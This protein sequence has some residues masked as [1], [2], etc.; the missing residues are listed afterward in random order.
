[1]NKLRKR[2]VSLLVVIAV[3][4][5][6]NLV[7]VMG[8]RTANAEAGVAGGDP[9]IIDLFPYSGT[10]YLRV[11]SDGQVDSL[12]RKQGGNTCD[13]SNIIVI[14]GPVDYPFPIVEVFI[15]PH[16]TTAM[17]TFEDGRVDLV[18]T[19]GG[20]N[21]CTIAGIGTPSLCTADTDRDGGGLASRGPC[22]STLAVM[23]WELRP[24]GRV[25]WAA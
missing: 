4:L 13:F 9:F 24:Q 20:L 23:W 8:S 21:R 5:T 12:E 14:A 2:I 19:A 18:G 25:C 11:W 22:A 16:G 7:L 10:L 1:M 6:L 15:P 3:M 17:M